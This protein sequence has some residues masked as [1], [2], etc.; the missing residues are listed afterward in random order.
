LSIAVA[1]RR[2]P[3]QPLSESAAARR[4][5]PVRQPGQLKEPGIGGFKLLSPF[6][7]ERLSKAQR[8]RNIQNDERVDRAQFAN[9]DNP[10]DEAAPIMADERDRSRTR[11]VYQSGDVARQHLKRIGFLCERPRRRAI[12]ALIRRPDP[13]SR[14]DERPDEMA[15]HDGVLGK[16]VQE[17]RKTIA[18]ARL[19]NLEF[20]SVGWN[21]N[22]T[23]AEKARRRRRPHTC[24][25]NAGQL[26]QGAP[27][28]IA[29]QLSAASPPAAG[30][31]MSD[32]WRST[33]AP[34]QA[35]HSGVSSKRD[36]VSNSCA[37]SLQ[38]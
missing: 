30:R 36:R 34:P 21:D 5:K 11:G 18:G 28:A 1:A 20:N 31:A 2:P 25:A 24:P 7:F 23:R 22:A 12:A 4:Q 26:G 32:N 38:R 6:L 14:R 8:V 35:G 27:P 3:H 13:I 15:P 10:G 19:K 17:Q 16:T 37:Q 29:A 33:W 9:S